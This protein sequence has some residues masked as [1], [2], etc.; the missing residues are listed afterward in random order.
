MTA[1]T[2]GKNDF[3][4]SLERL[5][6]IYSIKAHKYYFTLLILSCTAGCRSHVVTLV[7][8]FLLNSFHFDSLMDSLWICGKLT[9]KIMGWG[10]HKTICSCLAFSSGENLWYSLLSLKLSRIQLVTADFP[11]STSF[12]TTGSHTMICR[13][14]VV[15]V[16]LKSDLWN[17]R[18]KR[19]LIKRTLPHRPPE[20]VQDGP[21]AV[22]NKN[23]YSHIFINNIANDS[24]INLLQLLQI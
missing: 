6:R 8:C 20:R 24:L 21:L 10:L 2:D 14:Q 4:F 13:L 15:C 16:T 5:R 23:S 17:L 12:Y 18:I 9:L 22:S 19:L 7:C 11:Y 3:Q 1:V